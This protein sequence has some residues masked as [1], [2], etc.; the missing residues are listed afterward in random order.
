MLLLICFIVFIT[1]FFVIKGLSSPNPAMVKIAYRNTMIILGV[2]LVIILL[3]S[4]QPLIA[5]LATIAISAATYSRKILQILGT[6]DI[7]HSLLKKY[8]PNTPSANASDKMSKAEALEI[9]G[10]TANATNDEIESAYKRLMKNN[11]PD[12]GGSKYFAVKLN[13]AREVLLGR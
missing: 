6:L 7:F 8:R 1:L 11:H 5:A 13:Q 12:T 10:L 9:L 3:R 4:G 2:I